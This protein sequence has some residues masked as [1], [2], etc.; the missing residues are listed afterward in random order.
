MARRP[1]FAEAFAGRWRI[2]DMDTWSDD[3]LDVGGEAHISF[4]GAKDGEIAFVA[5]TAF[6]DVRYGTR[7]G[8]ATAEFTFEGLDEGD[9]ISGRGWASLGTAERL[10]GHV[11]IHKGE[12]SGFVCEPA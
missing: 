6:L 2:V 1:A 3:V 8:I 9:R 10:V 11:Y 7:D 12:D 4:T 5:V